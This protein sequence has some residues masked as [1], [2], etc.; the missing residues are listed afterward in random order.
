MANAFNS[1]LRG[2]VEYSCITG[3]HQ[4]RL[5]GKY[6]TLYSLTSSTIYI[7]LFIFSLRRLGKHSL[8]KLSNVQ[9]NRA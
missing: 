6:K 1:S 3:F 5:S 8:L 7:I 9:A 2:D 4:H